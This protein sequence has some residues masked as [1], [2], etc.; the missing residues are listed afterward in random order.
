MTMDGISNDK[1]RCEMA[2]I[3]S[4]RKGRTVYAEN[5][6]A[7]ELVVPVR[8]KKYSNTSGE[9]MMLVS[10]D[11]GEI[12]PAG[13]WTAKKV[14]EEQFVKLFA[15]GVK[16]FADLT[17][18]GVK[19]FELLYI[20][21]QKN[22]NQDKIYLSFDPSFEEKGLSERSYYRGLNELIEKNFI[23]STV[24]VGWY[25]VNPQYLWNGDRLVFAEE[26]VKVKNTQTKREDTKT[27]DM[28]DK[29]GE[30]N[31]EK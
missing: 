17:N 5:P 21:I 28:F 7:K 2:E 14:D 27:I 16:A 18:A 20:E 10:Q 11:T 12:R 15:K 9:K 31:G 8:T 26:F 24:K 19:V 3:V 25:F 23:A 29:E 22:I 4:K 30:E 13:F 1:K 6:F